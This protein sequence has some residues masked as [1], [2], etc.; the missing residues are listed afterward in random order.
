MRDEGRERTSKNGDMHVKLMKHFMLNFAKMDAELKPQCALLIL[1]NYTRIKKHLLTKWQVCINHR[2]TVKDIMS[3]LSGLTWQFS[4]KWHTSS[5]WREA[6]GSF[7]MFFIN[8]L[9]EMITQDWYWRIISIKKSHVWNEMIMAE[10]VQQKSEP[11][12]LQKCIK[13]SLYG[14]ASWKKHMFLLCLFQFLR[15]AYSCRLFWRCIVKR[16]VRL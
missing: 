16:F 12:M 8:P 14:E 13:S 2:A 3:S 7:V 15:E 4:I 9:P 11:S 10:E 6:T 1:T 5:E